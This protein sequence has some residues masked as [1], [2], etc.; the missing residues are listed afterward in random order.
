MGIRPKRPE[1]RGRRVATFWG[2]IGGYWMTEY[3]AP[4][5][6]QAEIDELFRLIDGNLGLRCP[7]G[8]P[9]VARIGKTELEKLFKRVV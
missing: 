1:A 2:T 5:L 7:H 9:V 8:R 4:Q 6:S 3:K